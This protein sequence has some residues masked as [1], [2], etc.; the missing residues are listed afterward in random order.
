VSGEYACV[1]GAKMLT[2]A[3]QKAALLE[4][5]KFAAA[6]AAVRSIVR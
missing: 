3:T 2:T 5:P 6:T 4:T 1:P